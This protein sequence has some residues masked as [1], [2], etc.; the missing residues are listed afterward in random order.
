MMQEKK[1][2]HFL[3]AKYNLLILSF[4]FRGKYNLDMFL[5]GFMI[6]PYEIK[7]KSNTDDLCP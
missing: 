6:R 5:G 2:I 1:V 4:D 7:H 3:Y